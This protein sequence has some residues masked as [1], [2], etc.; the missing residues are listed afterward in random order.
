MTQ[1]PSV[2]IAWHE[3]DLFPVKATGGIEVMG[4]PSLE[5]ASRSYLT[6]Q[7]SV[8][9]PSRGSFWGPPWLPAKFWDRDPYKHVTLAE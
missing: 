8:K 7:R 3:A 2:H 1:I 4:S 9:V 6:C 5:M